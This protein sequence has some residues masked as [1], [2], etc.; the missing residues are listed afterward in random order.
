MLRGAVQSLSCQKHG[1]KLSSRQQLHAFAGLYHKALN[2]GTQPCAVGECSSQQH[3]FSMSTACLHHTTDTNQ[4]GRQHCQGSLDSTADRMC[5]G[6]LRMM[7]LQAA[8]EVACNVLELAVFNQE[9][10]WH[11]CKKLLWQQ[12]L[13]PQ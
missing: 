11:S 12:T 2:F 6:E 8:G 5:L 3:V 4:G 10:W 1:R 13:Q 9:C 7:C